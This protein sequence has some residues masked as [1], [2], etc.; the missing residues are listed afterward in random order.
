[1]LRVYITIDSATHDKLQ[2]ATGQTILCTARHAMYRE[3]VVHVIA[4]PYTLH[5]SP[6]AFE[7]E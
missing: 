3:D 5:S 7:I 1:M 4:Q 2:F 6:I